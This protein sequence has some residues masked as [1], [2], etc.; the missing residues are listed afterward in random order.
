MKLVIRNKQQ[1]NQSWGI[2]DLGCLGVIQ[3]PMLCIL[4]RM[5]SRVTLPSGLHGIAVAKLNADVVGHKYGEI[6]A[7]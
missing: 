6:R 1:A 7:L 5:G 2:A 3:P 4:A